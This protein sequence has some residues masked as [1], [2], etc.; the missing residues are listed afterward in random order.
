MKFQNLKKGDRLGKI[1]LIQSQV[2]MSYSTKT[3]IRPLLESFDLIKSEDLILYTAHNISRLKHDL[4]DREISAVIFSSNSLSEKT[5]KEEVGSEGFKHIFDGFLAQG[6]GCLILHQLNSVPKNVYEPFPSFDFLPIESPKAVRRREDATSGDIKNTRLS[7]NHPLFHYPNTVS[8]DELK[9][10]CIKKKGLYWHYLDNSEPRAEW[11]TLLHDES[12]NQAG[13]A[14]LMATRESSKYRVVI[15]SL[16][17]D[18]QKETNLLKNLI[19]FVIDGKCNTAIIRDK[20][21]K[22]M[23]FEFFIETLNSLN[24]RYQEYE[25]SNT[26]MDDFKK[27]IH[28]GT[29]S[30]VVLAPTELNGENQ[31]KKE[32]IEGIDDFLQP[33]ITSGKI[34]YIGIESNEKSLKQFFVA[35]REKSALK[36]LQ[37]TEIKIHGILKEG[38]LIDD[39]FWNSV[40]TL[41]V[42]KSLEDHNL[43]FTRFTNDLV[44][45]IL[46]SVTS[47]SYLGLLV[48]TSALL[49][50]RANY[51]VNQVQCLQTINWIKEALVSGD[52]IESECIVACNTFLE[53][54]IETEF[55]TEKLRKLISHRDFKSLNEIETIHCIKAAILLR[56]IH[57]IRQFV[58]AL[59]SK[60]NQENLWIDI[61]ISANIVNLLLEALIILKEHEDSTEDLEKTIENLVFPTII[62]MQKLSKQ[63]ETDNEFHWDNKANTTLKCVSAILNFEELM[64][65]PVTEMVQSLV[66]YSQTGH[67]IIDNKTALNI[68][69]DYRKDISILNQKNTELEKQLKEEIR[70]KSEL[71]EVKQKLLVKNDQLVNKNDEY[72]DQIGKH[73]FRL[74]FWKIIIVL[75]IVSTLTLVF[76]AV[77][78]INNHKAFLDMIDFYNKYKVDLLKTIGTIFTGLISITTTNIFRKRYR[79]SGESM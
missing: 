79:K 53:L 28:Q 67:Q 77:Y 68:I 57:L 61:S 14:L 12:N 74:S 25:L 8:L 11:E 27:Q 72:E 63:P 47:D 45:P 21:N 39:S 7:E 15:S 31:G 40:D 56:D 50:L 70:R 58:T 4:T 32:L 26:E 29:H 51:S 33:Y 42:H 60:R 76:I 13:R 10:F 62:I 3:D 30:I 54:K 22:N 17:L 49:W 52:E 66:S 19:K 64:D 18:W 20:T 43:A 23:A 44:Q 2:Y 24:Y 38:K 65:I 55:A 75:G 48:P 73:V 34:K 59:E 9:Q 6:K 46:D 69:E 5:I 1:A 71:E 35:G 16:N 41:K 36:I 78:M 37:D